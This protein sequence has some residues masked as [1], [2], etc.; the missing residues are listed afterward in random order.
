MEKITNI[1]VDNENYSVNENGELCYDIIIDITSIVCE[2][3]DSI[4]IKLIA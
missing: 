3:F 1:T 4:I 2:P